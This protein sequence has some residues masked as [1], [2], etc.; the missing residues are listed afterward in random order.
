[1]H[2]LERK[3]FILIEMHGKTTINLIYCLQAKGEF[4]TEDDELSQSGSDM[5]SK[6]ANGQFL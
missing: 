5:S 3:E 4:K 6:S 1:V 2:L